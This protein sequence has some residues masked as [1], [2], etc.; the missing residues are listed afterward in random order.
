MYRVPGQRDPSIVWIRYYGIIP[1]TRRG[2][3]ITLAIVSA[4]VLLIL[5]VAFALGTLPPLS[6][7]WSPD[8]VWAQRGFAGWYYNYFYWFAI[9]C[10]VAQA[11]DTY[12]TMRVFAKREAAQRAKLMEV[13]EDA[14]S[15]G[16]GGGDSH[17]A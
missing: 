10:S 14:P 15:Q 13:A 6:T 16:R 7:L 5:L 2:Y 11:I 3:W 1:M 12:C 17:Q 4:S 9:V 8:P